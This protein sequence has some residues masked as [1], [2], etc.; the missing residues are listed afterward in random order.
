MFI[1]DLRA[2]AAR[3]HA[4]TIDKYYLDADDDM[5][6]KLNDNTL[7]QELEVAI[8]GLIPNFECMDGVTDVFVTFD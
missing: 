6:R 7:V 3:E 1:A 4:L 8:A 2:I 5:A